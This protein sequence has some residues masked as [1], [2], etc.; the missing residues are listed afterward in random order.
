MEI[1]LVTMTIGLLLSTAQ[2]GDSPK[3]VDITRPY[4]VQAVVDAAR[5]IG[6]P[7]SKAAKA[8]AKKIQTPDPI[9]SQIALMP[10]PVSD[11]E[12]FFRTYFK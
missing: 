1:G 11:R 8:Y 6:L 12:L 2:Y 4:I 7:S 9:L 10:D 3:G 5:I